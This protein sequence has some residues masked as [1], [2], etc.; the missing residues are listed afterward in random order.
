M[1]TVITQTALE[2][3]AC[4][5]G[6]VRARVFDELGGILKK[7]GRVTLAEEDNEKRIN[8]FL[9]MPDCKSI[10]VCLFS[11]CIAEKSPISEYAMGDDYHTVIKDRLSGVCEVLEKKGY[12]AMTF[13]DNSPLS[14]RHLAYLAGLGFFGKNTMLI[15]EEYG[16]KI[17]IG[18]VMTDCELEEDKP[19]D[20]DVCLNCGEC[21]RACPGGAIGDDFSFNENLCASFLTQKK[22]ELSAKEREII[23]KSGYIW[24]CDI[25]QDVCPYNHSAKLTTLDEFSKNLIYSI[26]VPPNMT[27]KEFKERYGTRAFAWRGKNVIIRNVGLMSENTD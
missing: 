15:N 11:Y 5:V 2:N 26:D 10:V 14:D 8:P 3:G 20:K 12:K 23:K 17:F 9:I 25:C 13:S 24:G 7:R 1:K 16:S 4:A 21:V 27:N 6:I 18:Y 19:L 22:G